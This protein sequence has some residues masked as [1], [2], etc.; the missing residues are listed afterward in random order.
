[1]NGYSITIDLFYESH[2]YFFLILD[3]FPHSFVPPPFFLGWKTDC[4]MQAYQILLKFLQS[5]R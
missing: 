3:S 4:T 5:S 1:M 2:S